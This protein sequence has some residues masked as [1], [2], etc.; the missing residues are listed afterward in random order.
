MTL[1]DQKIVTYTY[2][3]KKLLFA[4]SLTHTAYYMY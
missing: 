3:Y 1:I 4:V 2:L